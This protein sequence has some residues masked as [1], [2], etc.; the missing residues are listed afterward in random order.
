MSISLTIADLDDETFRRLK[1]E[2][3]RRGV[4]I[5]VVAKNLLTKNLPATTAPINGGTNGPPYHD[6][7]FLSGTWTEQEAKD[8]LES[9]SDL[10]R[11]DP[12]L[13]Q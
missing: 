1:A 10:R 2:A 9:I 3:D 7:D 5:E 8:F 11:I 4:E 6:L 13:W 12:E